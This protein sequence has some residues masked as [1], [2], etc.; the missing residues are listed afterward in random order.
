MSGIIG[1]IK[2][3]MKKKFV[4]GLNGD[5]NWSSVS[6][7]LTGDDLVDH[8]SNP[9]TVTPYGNTVISTS[10]KKYGTGSMYFDGGGDYL[11]IPNSAAFALNG[12][13]FTFETWLNTTNG[14][15]CPIL[16]CWHNGGGW[17]FY[18]RNNKMYFYDPSL[19]GEQAS[20]TVLSN[21][22][23]YHL[24]WVLSGSTLRYFINGTL[25]D[26][27]SGVTVS[28]TSNNPHVGQG[29]IGSE[30]FSGYLDDLRL[31]KG[32]ARYTANFTP[33]TAALPTSAGAVTDPNWNNVELLLTGDDLLDR[34]VVTKSLTSN[35]SPTVNTSIKKY[36]TGSFYGDGA[37]SLSL[38]TAINLTGDFTIEGWFYKATY[39]SFN[40]FASPGQA[41]PWFG[42]N[43]NQ[44]LYFGSSTNQISI[45]NMDN[46]WTHIA[47]VRSGTSIKAYINGSDI[48]GGTAYTL[49]GTVP[50]QYIGAFGT[51][52][53]GFRGYI[54]D[55][56]ITKDVARY[57]SNFTPSSSAL[58]INGS[59]GADTNWS[60]VTLLLT[61]DDLLDHSNSPKTIT[62]YGDT[63][64]STTTKKYGTGSIYF[65]G[66]GDYLTTG[67]GRLYTNGDFTIDCWVY[68]TNANAVY[69]AIFT[70]NALVSWQSPNNSQSLVVSANGFH[71][72]G[73]PWTTYSSG[74]SVPTGQWVHVA[75]VKSSTNV[76]FYFD[77]VSRH[78][79]SHT[80]YVGWDGVT[81]G[82]G[83]FDSE[84]GPARL[85]WN[86]YIDDFRI[87]TGLARYTTNFTPPTSAAPTA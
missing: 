74:Y 64:V 61:G 55:F 29:N 31:T 49:S 39:S 14:S 76:K 9:K 7:L 63:I 84:G 68:R 83:V 5:P 1:G 33:P 57:T 66:T 70:T 58:P 85:F 2:G 15:L 43:G 18:L 38:S 80:G 42:F 51:T 47:I 45:S 60:A 19:A 32:V 25:T 28:A 67:T 12:G 20:S 81:Q 87:T 40:I 3:S 17:T 59:A 10:T 50:I 65:D 21:N 78:S 16:A 52:S 69:D 75:V 62:K 48:T 6:L 41:D 22:T 37:S 54:D 86:G 82:V 4:A 77:G 53:Y 56:R 46:T 30:F 23:W 8:S 36:G 79:T 13:D 35:G 44:T 34:S 11:D 71:G 27:F 26:T 24:A 72:L 73:L